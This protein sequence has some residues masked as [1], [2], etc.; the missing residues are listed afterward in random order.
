MLGKGSLDKEQ[1]IQRLLQNHEGVF[2]ADLK[3]LDAFKCTVCKVDNLKWI[4]LEGHLK[5]K[6]HLQE[7]ENQFDPFEDLEKRKAINGLIHMKAGSISLRSDETSLYFKLTQFILKN[8]LAFSA[9]EPFIKVLKEL[10]TDFRVEVLKKIQ[11]SPTTI[12][13][14]L[15]TALGR[16]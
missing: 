8:R 3:N 14:L 16:S 9:I 12:Q 2:E 7:L 5:S 15:Q 1:K 10:I 6:R 4:S 11:L 13:K